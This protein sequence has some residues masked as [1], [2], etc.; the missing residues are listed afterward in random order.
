MISI[1]IKIRTHLKPTLQDMLQPFNNHH[2]LK[3]ES[4]EVSFEFIICHKTINNNVKQT[5]K[6]NRTAK[7]NKR[8]YN[9]DVLIRM[10]ELR[11]TIHGLAFMRMSR[12]CY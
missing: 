3:A 1:F 12:N 7:G 5:I 11:S 10:R 9:I 2:Q 8:G 4:I 6:S